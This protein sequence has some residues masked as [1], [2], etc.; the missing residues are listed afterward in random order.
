MHNDKLG[1]FRLS[2]SLNCSIRI[3]YFDDSWSSNSKL[4]S[5]GLTQ[6][7]VLVDQLVVV[8]FSPFSPLSKTD[9][10]LISDCFRLYGQP[11]VQ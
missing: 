1:K 6:T 11:I 8:V 9:F 5:Q 2:L 3:D 7:L 10:N 4:L